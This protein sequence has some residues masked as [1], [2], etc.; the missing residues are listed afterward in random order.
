MPIQ[1]IPQVAKARNGLGAFILQCKNIEFGYCEWAGSSRGLNRFLQTKL[2]RFAAQNSQI[3]FSVTKR[4]HSHPI[5]RGTYINGRE[6]VICVRN[7]DESEILQK[8][9]LLKNSS[10]NK[11]KRRR[12]PV[13]SSNESV[14]GI[15]SP[16][17]TT[18][19]TI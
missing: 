7:M 8:C 1:V 17:A 14:R 12:H 3:N 15:W 18:K 19:H 6:K 2:P 13:E 5:V 16:F 11:L 10:G 9:E 4:P